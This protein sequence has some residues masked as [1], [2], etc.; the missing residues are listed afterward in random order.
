MTFFNHLNSLWTEVMEQRHRE[1]WA[2]GMSAS[3]IRDTLNS[4]FNMNFTRNA[5]IGKAERLKLPKRDSKIFVQHRYTTEQLNLIRSR[6][7][8]G[9]TQRQIAAAIF[10]KY[11]V[12][13]SENSVGA[14]MRRNKIKG[15]E[16]RHG[17]GRSAFSR[18]PKIASKTK[19]N[20]GRGYWYAPMDGAEDLT[21]DDPIADIGI[22]IFDLQANSCRFPMARDP[23]DHSYRFCGQPT[24]RDENCQFRW[25]SYCG[26]HEKIAYRPRPKEVAA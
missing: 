8:K 24:D 13:V 22:G 21:R 20:G 10:T 26:C 23:N 4:E 18:R 5:V 3:A 6:A 1:L 15:N 11:G 16:R 25:K 9:E 17:M 2:N 14:V 7:A 19:S 12:R